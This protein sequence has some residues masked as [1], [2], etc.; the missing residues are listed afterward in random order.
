MVVQDGQDR[1]LARLEH[2]RRPLVPEQHPAGIE[3]PFPNGQLPVIVGTEFVD[4]V[5]DLLH[6]VLGD[7]VEDVFLVGDVVVERHRLG[8]DDLR[9]AAHGERGET[10]LV[11]DADRR[12]QHPIPAERDAR[13]RPGLGNHLGHRTLAGLR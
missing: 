4:D 1:G 10:L 6:H 13:L 3:N 2:G 5:V 7:A 8:P 9:E 11:G 12:A